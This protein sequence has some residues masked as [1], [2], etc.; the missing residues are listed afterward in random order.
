M[1]TR[2]KI[3]IK[4]SMNRFYLGWGTQRF[5]FWGNAKPPSHLQ[6]AN[7]PVVDYNTCKSIGRWRETWS[8]FFYQ[9]SNTGNPSSTRKLR[10][11]QLAKSQFHDHKR[12]YA[13]SCLL[14]FPIVKEKNEHK[15]RRFLLLLRTCANK[16]DFQ[17]AIWFPAGTGL[18]MT[19]TR[20][21][22]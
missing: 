4:Y 14:A 8:E 19:R 7:V 18:T 11:V 5:S 3:S 10:L 1:V 6:Q 17:S 20:W 22:C 16:Y 2:G 12:N 13:F 15:Q 9:D 21:V